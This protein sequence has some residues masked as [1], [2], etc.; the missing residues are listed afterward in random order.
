MGFSE[1]E[2]VYGFMH[3]RDFLPNTFPD[4]LNQSSGSN[5]LLC[6]LPSQGDHSVYISP[7]IILH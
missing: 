7:S 5:V 1:K 3:S 4:A 6:P 2:I